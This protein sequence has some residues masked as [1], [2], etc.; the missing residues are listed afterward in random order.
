[1]PRL[2]VFACGKSLH[3]G[4]WLMQDGRNL[5]P[6]KVHPY[7][8]K[9]VDEVSLTGQDLVRLD[10]YA[11]TAIETLVAQGYFVSQTPAKVLEFSPR[12]KSRFSSRA[13]ERRN[14]SRRDAFQIGVVGAAGSP[15]G[16][17][18]RYWL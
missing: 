4:L 5:P 14:H 8:W 11:W 9:R 16:F 15:S 2:Y 17:P 3:V 18:R 6:C 10:V 1:M 12:L 7:A 13:R